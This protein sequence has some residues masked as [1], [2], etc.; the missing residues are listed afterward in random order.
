MLVPYSVAFPIDSRIIQLIRIFYCPSHS[1]LPYSSM[2]LYAVSKRSPKHFCPSLVEMIDAYAARSNTPHHTAFSQRYGTR[3]RASLCAEGPYLLNG[4][5]RYEWQDQALPFYDAPVLSVDV[6]IFQARPCVLCCH[7]CVDVSI[8]TRC[9][10]RLCGW[11]TRECALRVQ[12]L[13]HHAVNLRCHNPR[14]LLRARASRL[15][16]DAELAAMI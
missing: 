2:P 6:S 3:S 14:V 9:S 1:P 7:R 11:H 15:I 5:Y 10:S 4:V 12:G 8:C 13:P 16:D